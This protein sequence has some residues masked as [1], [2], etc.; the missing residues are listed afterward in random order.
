VY[1]V[2]TGATRVFGNEP[3]PP[4]LADLVGDIAPRATFFVYGE[5]G[6]PQEIDLNPTYH[7]AAGE[8]TELWEVPGS[9]HIDGL[10]AQPE[11]Y[12]RRVIGF[13]D[14]HLLGE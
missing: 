13:L 4:N 3:V 11:E 7:D 2:L 8:P 5:E 1:G 10:D 9:G 6:Q 14:R 12:E